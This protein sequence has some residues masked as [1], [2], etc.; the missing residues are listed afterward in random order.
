M[1]YN[2]SG[3]FSLSDTIANGT[4]G[5]ADEVQ[6]ILDDIADG[7]STS[8]ANDGQSTMTGPAKLANGSAAA[9]A[10]TSGSDTDTG[11]Y[12]KG[13]NNWGAAAGGADVWE[14]TTSG[15]VMASGKTISGMDAMSGS[16]LS[17]G[18]VALTKLASQA[19]GTIVAN[20]S[21]SSAV[22]TASTITAVIDKIYSTQGGLL[23]RGASAW[24]GLAVGTSGQFLKT[25]GAGANPTWAT[26]SEVPSQSGASGKFLKSDGSTAS[27]GE[28][29]FAR[30]S[31]TF[32]GTTATTRSSSNMASFVRQAL[33]VWRFTFTTAASAAGAYT[34]V[35]TGH[36][37]TYNAV[38]GAV[39]YANRATT[40]FDIAIA[41]PGGGLLEPASIE[42]LVFGA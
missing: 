40:Y 30:A 32:S 21:G 36:D 13:A 27:W 39:P 9:P 2:G 31:I 14:W 19:D 17:A 38:V 5:D 22:P 3:A 8:F 4:P 25:Q 23:Y 20:V 18:S 10:L 24:T 26:I 11:F 41:V 16:S 37:A 34:V 7:L 12:R 6:A 1:P 35:A 33:G 15:I 42:I 28:S 29:C